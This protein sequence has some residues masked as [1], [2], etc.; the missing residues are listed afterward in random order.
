MAERKSKL[1]TPA[2]WQAVDD[3]L[4]GREYDPTL[5]YRVRKKVE[6]MR[7]LQNDTRLRDIMKRRKRVMLE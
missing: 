7:E 5:I 3:Y 1:I 4:E 6:E 2:E